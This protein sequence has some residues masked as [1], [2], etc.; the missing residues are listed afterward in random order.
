MNAIEQKLTIARRLTTTIS[1]ALVI[2]A[3]LASYHIV[4]AD[5]D[6]VQQAQRTAIAAWTERHVLDLQYAI[7]SAANAAEAVAG[8]PAVSGALDGDPAALVAMQQLTDTVARSNP[9]FLQVRLIALDGE[10]REL[11]RSERKD[12][13]VIAI[14]GQALQNKSRE[15][16]TL[17][18]RN[19]SA[20]QLAYSKINLNREH[21][22]VQIPFVP[23]IRAFVRTAPSAG[24]NDGFVI[25]NLNLTNALAYL[26]TLVPRN[27][28]IYF[29]DSEGMLLLSPEGDF[30][31]QTGNPGYLS[32]V[33]ELP[34]TPI[35]ESSP[36]EGESDDG[37]S[38]AGWYARELALGNNEHP[39][40][41]TLVVAPE[42]PAAIWSVVQASLLPLVVV[43]SVAAFL[44]WFVYYNI[45]RNFTP[46]KDLVDFA[47]SIGE[48]NF[49]NPVPAIKA[50]DLQKVAN[51]LAK[52]Q[53]ALATYETNVI[54]GAALNT[55]PTALM[56]VDMH[57]NIERINARAARMLG[58]D[59]QE[60]IGTSVDLLVPEPQRGAHGAVRQAYFATPQA[61]PMAPGRDLYAQ[62]KNGNL[63]PVNITLSPLRVQD[64][65][66]VAATVFDLTE[67]KE[68]ES[69]LAAAKQAA[70]AANEA[71]SMFLANMSHEIRTPLNGMLGIAQLLLDSPLS[72]RQRSEVEILLNSGK[73]LQ[74]VLNSILDFTR[75]EAD[76]LELAE[77][78][79]DLDKLCDE[80]LSLFASEAERKGIELLLDIDPKIPNKLI[81]DDFHLSQVLNNL[82]GNAVK[83]TSRGQVLLKLTGTPRNDGKV[84]LMVSVRDTG[85]GM[86]AEQI[87]KLFQPFQQADPST[88][89]RFGGTGLG[90]AL[91]QR[92]IEL[93]DGRIEATSTF[94]DGST[95]KFHILVSYND[96]VH[97]S[98]LR[99]RL[100]VMRALVVDDNVTS[101]QIIGGLL[102]NWGLEVAGRSDAASGLEAL[103]D[104]ERHG[105]PFDILVL[106]WKMP[107]LDGVGMIQQMDATLDGYRQR[108]RPAIIMVTAF[109]ETLSDLPLKADHVKAFI[110]KP[111]SPSRLYDAIVSIQQDIRP[112]WFKE[113]LERVD[114]ATTARHETLGSRI[115]LVEDHATNQ[116]VAKGL[117]ER[118]NVQVDV[119]DNGRVALA[120]ARSNLYDLILM[121]LQMPLMDGFEATK[122]LRLLPEYKDTPIVAMTAAVT[123]EDRAAT[124]AAG[125]ND[126]L[127]K[128][129]DVQQLTE[130]LN[131]W[132]DPARVRRR[133]LARGEDESRTPS[134]DL[135]AI[136]ELDIQSA[137]RRLDG[138]ENLLRRVL[139]DFAKDFADVHTRIAQAL[140]SGNRESAV[141]QVHI[142][143]GMA[144][145]IGAKHLAASAERLEQALVKSTDE[146][147]KLQ[148]S[149]DF[150]SQLESVL[151]IVSTLQSGDKSGNTPAEKNA[152]PA[153]ALKELSQLL[154]Q[155]TIVP[156]RAKDTVHDLL[157]GKVSD[158]LISTLIANITRLDY[159]AAERD[160]ATI[161]M[162]LDA[163]AQSGS[164]TNA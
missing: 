156:Q 56:V 109:A 43:W 164:R 162:Q 127:P 163:G 1:V 37:W 161:L 57:G 124:K 36:L 13:E 89:R 17:A 159:E 123:E 19:L 51:A 72:S 33:A 3:G 55:V 115:L 18:A 5:R 39:A 23:V 14:V 110:Q 148:V 153:K 26:R 146:T 62:C 145:N 138:D 68:K 142:V 91:A 92:I 99:D 15:P 119:A 126:H 45:Y 58:Y 87:E 32:D 106:D 93:M 53:Q 34:A 129:I 111:V 88:R 104:A 78:P 147:E 108:R 29:V 41:Y 100:D 137:L 90:L 16:Y 85:I 158:E 97:P 28:D 101:Q 154:Q 134:V 2:L 79:F 44:G 30:T 48:G 103:A 42:S 46:L 59:E 63:I 12:G 66:Y 65:T 130:M 77:R 133:R 121:D 144:G 69:E 61:Q 131:K 141:E 152:D 20:G 75:I 160:L 74:K 64:R 60:L 49:Q 67:H 70:D 50:P 139:G 76:R 118:M 112:D 22:Q 150:V 31:G 120:M 27:A 117:I 140:A 4:S 80:T 86:T 95:F 10:G 35:T 24:A 149:V 38:P 114:E 7:V 54:F 82:V 71:K 122:A 52:T 132:I 94:G 11:V 9:N 151:S 143:R 98:R 40:R 136:R 102:T 107:V 47:A 83:F 125:M 128:P 155:S 135:M 73:T 105:A 25:V 157:S 96:E 116:Y 81:A 8:H 113:Q 84:E 21:G 6:Q